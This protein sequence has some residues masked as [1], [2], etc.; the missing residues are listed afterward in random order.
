MLSDEYYEQD[1]KEQNDLMHYRGFPHSLGSNSEQQLKPAA[2]NKN[3]ARSSRVLNGSENFGDGDEDDNNNDD[4]DYEE[5]EDEDDPDDADFEPD[6]GITSEHTLK[7]D[8]NWGGAESEEE[9]DSDNELDMSDEDDFY[10]ARKSKSKQRGK[11]GHIVKSTRECKLYQ[12]S[13]QQRRGKSSFEDDESL[14][15]DS[16]SDSDVGFK[17]TRK[18][19]HQR[20]TSG[21]STFSI[22]ATGRNN[23]VR[24][25]SRSVR[26]V[27]YVESDESEDADESKKKNLQKEELEEEDSDCIETVMWH[28]P[29]GVVEEAL[30]SKRS[31]D[32]VL[33]SYLFDSEP[34]WN[35][36]E[37][38]IKWKGQSHLHCQ[39]KSFS[40]L[41]NLS[42]FKK[43]LN[44]TK[45]VTDEVRFRK[46][47]TREEI[48][49]NDVSKEMDLDL[50]KQNSQ[51]ERIISDRISK[52]SSGDVIPENLVKWQGLSYAEATWL[53]ALE[54][55]TTHTPLSSSQCS[56]M[57]QVM[58]LLANSHVVM[59][60]ESESIQMRVASHKRVVVYIG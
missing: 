51:V 11:G 16:E 22:N 48:E 28:Q 5:D 59:W 46:T 38:L 43:V 2:G 32:H 50:I 1:G 39:W 23:E 52:D 54:N 25:S 55:S 14:G 27:S 19:S 42:G 15:E 7:K 20:K 13:G 45:K 33:L 6:Y 26:K 4:A 8:K 57:K 49:V 9:D 41:Q 24:T 21:R 44:Y 36:M 34:N 31:T 53:I 40:K 47:V 37:F 17:S 60:R 18:G 3:T 30:R 58:L 35:E 29:K 12:G 10:Y 56:C